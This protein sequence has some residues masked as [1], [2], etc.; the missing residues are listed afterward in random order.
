MAAID[1]TNGWL[2]GSHPQ[3]IPLSLA[4]YG[5]MQGSIWKHFGSVKNQKRTL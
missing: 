5:T 4:P 3:N 1:L 2:L